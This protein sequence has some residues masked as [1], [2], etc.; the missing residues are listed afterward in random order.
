MEK[1]DHFSGKIFREYRLPSARID[2]ASQD[3]FIVP[4]M[5]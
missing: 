3:V 2:S 4:D 5:C 1:S